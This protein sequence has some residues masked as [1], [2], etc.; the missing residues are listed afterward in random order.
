[1]NE[2][3]TSTRDK[4]TRLFGDLARGL[5]GP[6]QEST[7]PKVTWWLPLDPNNEHRGPADVER[8]LIACLGAG[9]VT[10]ESVV[11]AEDG[12]TAVVEQRIARRGAAATT[13]T[14]LISLT[15]GVI[16]AGRTYVDLAASEGRDEGWR[17]VEH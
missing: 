16:T 5:G 7:S 9:D 4:V 11:V 17:H 1:M 12:S 8:A 10:L 3:Q 6:F 14:S 2:S 15:D 13:A